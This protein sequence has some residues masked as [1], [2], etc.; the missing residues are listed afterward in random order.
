MGLVF[1][2]NLSL[3]SC[4]RLKETGLGV[5]DYAKIVAGGFKNKQIDGF[6]DKFFAK[7]I[8]K[9]RNR[10]ALVVWEI[11]KNKR[12]GGSPN[13]DFFAVFVQQFSHQLLHL[14]II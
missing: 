11:F 5:F 3:T 9:N 10:L 13:F 1:L 8:G 12:R 2:L 4:P 7:S 6:G 14:K